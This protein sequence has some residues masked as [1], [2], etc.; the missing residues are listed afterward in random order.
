MVPNPGDED[1]VR[2]PQER[3]EVG[4]VDGP[5]VDE[6]EAEEDSDLGEVED[7]AG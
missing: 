6:A 3:E 2:P 7:E 5:E 1:E 4:E